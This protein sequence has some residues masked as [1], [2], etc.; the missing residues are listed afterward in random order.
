MYVG[1]RAMGYSMNCPNVCAIVKDVGL[2]V[3]F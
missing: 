2:I 3:V 1:Y